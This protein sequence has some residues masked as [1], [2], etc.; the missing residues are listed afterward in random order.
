MR[1]KLFSIKSKLLNMSTLKEEKITIFGIV[2]LLVL[3]ITNTLITIQ[4][5]I[6]VEVTNYIY[7]KIIG[8]ILSILFLVAL[9]PFVLCYSF[10]VYDQI[11]YLY[12]FG[13]PELRFILYIIFM[14]IINVFLI[15]NWLDQFSKDV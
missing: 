2:I 8:S 4:K 12:P 10:I 6:P 11:F 5:G 3:G 15:R 9:F 13:T 7:V 1:E 14:P